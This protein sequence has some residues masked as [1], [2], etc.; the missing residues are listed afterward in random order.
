MFRRDLGAGAEL[1]LLQLHDAAELLAFVQANRAH[2]GEWLLWV[3]NVQT[4]ADAEHFIREGLAEQGRSGLAALGIWQD[5]QMAGGIIPFPLESHQAELGYWLGQAYVG[6]GLMT[7]ALR[8]VLE[9]L[10]VNHKLERVQV[11]VEPENF[12]SRAVP[13]R[14]GFTYTGIE[15]GGWTHGDRLV[16]L[17]VYA[18][19]AEQ[20]SQRSAAQ[21]TDEES[22]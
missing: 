10:F 15:P 21:P 12:R 6:K 4:Q 8:R 7:R 19:R 20:W 1:R 2:L 13:E 16:D 17:A 14:L 9:D 11:R 3:N 18:L 22:G 5:G